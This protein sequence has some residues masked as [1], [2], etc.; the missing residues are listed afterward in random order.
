VNVRYKA[1][2][3]NLLT[4]LILQTAQR[5]TEADVV[6]LRTAGLADTIDLHLA[7]DGSF[8]AASPEV[9]RPAVRPRPRCH[10]ADEQQS[11]RIRSNGLA[12]TREGV[13]GR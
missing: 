11:N 4:V 10:R 2:A 5:A 3:S 7:L 13:Q 6:K 1:G 9:R 8:D 12:G